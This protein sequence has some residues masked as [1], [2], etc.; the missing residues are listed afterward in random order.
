MVFLKALSL[1]AEE[2]A[3]LRVESY[4][5]FAEKLL[6]V[7]NIMATSLSNS[8]TLFYCGNGGSAAEAQHIAAEMV[9]RF[10]KTIKRPPLSAIALTTDSSILSAVANDFSYEDVFYLQIGALAR[11][12]DILF[13][14]ST[15][16]N[17]PNIVKAIQGA[18]DKEMVIIGLT[19]ASG[20]MMHDICDVIFNIPSK[21]T[22]LIQ[23][24]HLA[25]HHSLCYMVERILYPPI[26]S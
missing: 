5:L 24:V 17:S 21:E 4:S 1:Y 2:G 14:S 15:S 25:F 7:A 18:K 26:S 3:R 9:G 8:G 13:V 23:E 12:G 20:G 19:G 22:P 16:G 6:S 10:S 11:K